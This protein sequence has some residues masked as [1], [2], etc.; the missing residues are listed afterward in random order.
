MSVP[1][2]HLPRPDDDDPRSP[3]HERAILAAA[4]AARLR[5]A[6]IVDAETKLR[7]R[8]ALELAEQ[9]AT[10]LIPGH[11]RTDITRLGDIARERLEHFVRRAPGRRKRRV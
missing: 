3:E 8:L 5:S 9:L 1:F 6:G 7:A 11:P 2:H 10:P 4:A